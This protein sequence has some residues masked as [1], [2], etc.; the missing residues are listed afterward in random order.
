MKAI[1]INTKTD[2]SGYLKINIPLKKSNKKVKLLILLTEDE[3][4]TEDEQYWLYANTQ[5]PS[6]DF[7]NEPEEDIYS[8]ND[9]EP[10]ENEK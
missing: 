8:L 5:N 6:F 9:G 7:L 2:D 4:S 1:E 3:E 10:I